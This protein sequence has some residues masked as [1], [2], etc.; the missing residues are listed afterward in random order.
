[1]T[2]YIQLSDTYRL[3]KNKDDFSLEQWKEEYVTNATGGSE[4]RLK[5]AQWTPL[6]K[7][8]PTITLGVKYAIEHQLCSEDGTYSLQEYVFHQE[9]LWDIMKNY[10]QIEGELEDNPETTP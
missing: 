7:Y 9:T 1:M 4:S 3:R 8:F 5:P 10:I 2:T 6:N